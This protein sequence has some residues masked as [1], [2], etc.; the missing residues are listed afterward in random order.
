MRRDGRKYSCSSTS[1]ATTQKINPQVYTLPSCSSSLPALGSVEHPDDT[2][3]RNPLKYTTSGQILGQ[4]LVIRGRDHQNLSKYLSW[5]RILQWI[6]QPRIVRVFHSAPYPPSH[7]KLKACGCCASWWWFLQD[8]DQATLQQVM[9]VVCVVVFFFII[10][11][12][13]FICFMVCELFF[14]FFMVCGLFFSW[15][16]DSSSSSS[17]CL[18]KVN[19]TQQQMIDLICCCCI[20]V[21]KILMM[22]QCTWFD[23]VG[24]FCLVQSLWRN[25][26]DANLHW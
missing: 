17:S 25:R 10:Y 14:I 24:F 11:G 5:S 23:L 18:A 20:V 9:V 21:A 15:F 26:Q 7:D 6:S 4:I 16:A 22:L 13:F 19:S 1:S 12:L 3:L 2:R 8:M